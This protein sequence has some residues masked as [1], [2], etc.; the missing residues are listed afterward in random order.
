MVKKSE[1]LL[2]DKI[3]EGFIDHVNEIGENPK[4]VAH[5]CKSLKIQESDFYEHFSDIDQIEAHIPKKIWEDTLHSLSQQEFYANSTEQEKVLSVMYGFFENAKSYRSYLL[6]KYKNQH[7][8]LEKLKNMD[9][10]R[11]SVM[12][13]FQS[14]NL[15]TALPKLGMPMMD[16]MGDKAVSITLYSNFVFIFNFWLND[17]SSQF[18]KTD[19]LIEKVF[20]LSFD[21]MD[22]TVLNKVLD[23]GKFLLGEIRK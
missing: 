16:K 18:E 10:F 23:L 5:L 17:K 22:P 3:I 1:Q 15:E 7:N 20:T 11:K 2:S 19:A 21:L 4:S 13:Y 8:P 14:L 12:D 9:L 6:L